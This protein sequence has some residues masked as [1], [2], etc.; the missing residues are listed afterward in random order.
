MSEEN[1]EEWD[2][3]FL[4]QLIQVEE[5][6]LS[7][8]PATTP[9]NTNTDTQTALSSFQQPQL[10]PPLNVDSFTSYSPPRE[11]SQRIPAPDSTSNSFHPIF[12]KSSSSNDNDDVKDLEIQRL[13]VRVSFPALYSSICYS[14]ICFCFLLCYWSTIT[15]FLT[16]KDSIMSVVEVEV[17]NS[18]EF[19]YP[20]P[21]D[22]INRQMS[23]RNF[24]IMNTE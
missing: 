8:L 20:F 15:V 17:G 14:V 24:L 12:A 6:A 13:K 3:D 7:K 10:Q 18:D 5:L 4:D 19:E 16:S 23:H 22:K 1:F 11:L 9:S 2:A 21:V